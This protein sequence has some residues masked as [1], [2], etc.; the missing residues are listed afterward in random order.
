MLGIRR[1]LDKQT[2]RMDE[3]VDKQKDGKTGTEHID[4]GSGSANG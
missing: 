3:K 4:L 2:G 1:L